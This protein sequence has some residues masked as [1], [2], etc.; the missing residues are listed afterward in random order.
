MI[1]KNNDTVDG[2]EIPN[3]QPPFGMYY[4]PNVNDGRNYH[5]NWL[6]SPDFFLN[7]QQYHLYLPK[8]H[9]L[10]HYAQDCLNAPLLLMALIDHRC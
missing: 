3:N 4:E 2:S 6:G 8:N 7:H 10:G 9:D 1:Q 5:I